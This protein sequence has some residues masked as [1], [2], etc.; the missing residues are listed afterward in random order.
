MPEP[1]QSEEGVA[2]GIH[3]AEVGAAPEETLRR[4]A[5]AAETWGGEWQSEGNRAGKLILPVS[6]GVRRGWM[7]F[8]VTAT[9][10]AADSE[11]DLDETQS[12]RLELRRADEHLRVD[13]ATMVMLV[14]SALGALL[15][16]VVPFAP[17]LMPLLPVG[18]ILAVAGWLFIASRLRNS[19]A[20]EF[21]EQLT[22]DNPP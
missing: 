9:D 1:I 14:T 6:A 18:F 3:V 19:G 4:V 22:E 13:R 10:S 21:L 20:E 17:R 15:F 16:L 12:S 11:S 5:E 7:G 8:E 2:L